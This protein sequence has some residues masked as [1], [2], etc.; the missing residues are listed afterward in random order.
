MLAELA[1]RFPNFHTFADVD[2]ISIYGEAPDVAQAVE[3][4][5]AENERRDEAPNFTKLV[6]SSGDPTS[7]QHPASVALVAKAEMA[8]VAKGIHGIR[9]VTLATEG[10]KTLGVPIGP[11]EWIVNWLE[12][13]GD[14]IDGVLD[15]ISVDGTHS[16]LSR[17]NHISQ[18]RPRMM[19][20]LAVLP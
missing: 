4:W 17:G 1:T 9:I 18:P 20:S 8:A 12:Q 7:L 16:F 2:D 5:N 10:R 14:K 3:W 6:L 13:K 19:V 15:M 11:D